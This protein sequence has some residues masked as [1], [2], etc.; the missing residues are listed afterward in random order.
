MTCAAAILAGGRARRMGG[1]PKSFVEVDGE[2]IINRQLRALG[3]LFD[4][5]WIVVAQTSDHALYAGLGPRIAADVV[6]GQL[7]PLVGILTAIES[8]HADRVVCV[9]CDMPFLEPRSLELVR[10]HAPD[11]EIVVPV[12]A[13]R[14]E[15]LLAR[16]ARAVAPRIRAL[17]AAG[18]RAAKCIAE[19]PRAVELPEAALRAI[20]KN[21]RF[22][23]NFNIPNINA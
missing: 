6:P 3:G 13:G 12:V 7:G 20:D 1:R 19:D 16:Y 15:P 17:L 5:I 10:D 8:A 11:A 9:A 2:R 14:V 22:L 18:D 21:L 23:N 4:E